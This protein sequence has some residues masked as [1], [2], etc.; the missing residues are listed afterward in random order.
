MLSVLEIE[1]EEDVYALSLWW[2]CRSVLRKKLSEEAGRKSVE[3]RGD[4]ASRSEQRVEEEQVSMRLETLNLSGEEMGEQGAGPI[5]DPKEAR[6]AGG[7][8]LANG[9][10]GLKLKGVANR[11]D[12]PEASPS[13]RRWA[14][15]VGC[16]ASSKGPVTS[17]DQASSKGP[18]ISM[19]CQKLIDL[20]GKARAGPVSLADQASSNDSQEKGYLLER[21]ISRNGNSLEIE[22]FVA[23]ESEDLRK[24]QTFASY[25]VIDRALEEEALRDLGVTKRSSDKVKGT[26]GA[27]GTP[28]IQAVRNEPEEK[29]EESSLAKFSHF[30]GFLTEGLEKEILN[31]LIKTRKRWEKIHSKELLEKSKFERE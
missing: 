15:E 14:E 13:S 11:E 22:P 3:V 10:L 30:L 4:V 21:T 7:L 16:H 1:V 18:I 5:M 2:E 17:K 8:G 27:F 6:R 31:F 26:E 28:E 19:G 23:W 24:Q 29:W 20:E 25:S 9:P 12:G